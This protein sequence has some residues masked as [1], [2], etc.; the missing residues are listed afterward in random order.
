M[1]TTTSD[2]DLVLAFLVEA[3]GERVS[4]ELLAGKL[5]L[6]PAALYR[7]IESLR[8]RGFDVESQRGQGYRLLS[9][10]DRLDPAEITAH[11]STRELG[12]AIHHHAVLA[13][14]NDEAQRLAKAGAAHGEVVIADKQ[15]A[16]RGRRGRGWVSP[17]RVNLHLSVIL[18]PE[19]PPQRAPELVSLVAVAAAE[20]LLGFDVPVGIKWPNDLEADGRKIGGILL[21]LSAEAGRIHFVVVGLGLNLNASREDFPEEVRDVATSIRLQ[22]GGPVSRAEAAASLLGDLERWLDRFEAEG[23]EPVRARYSELS[24][25]LGQPVRLIE[26]ER[27][28]EGVAESIDESGALIVRKQDGSVERFLSGDVTSLRRSG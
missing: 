6:H 8:S 17:A 11:L 16:G 25:I 28:L 18:R 24:S 22:H 27:T 5:G 12:W 2:A 21:D 10:P 26:A 3:E 14:T 1:A 13:S 23:F 19:L 9:T 20:T 4:A 15:T 7:A